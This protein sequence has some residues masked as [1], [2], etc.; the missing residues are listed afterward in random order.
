VRPSTPRNQGH[1][2][3]PVYAFM[4]QSTIP[5]GRLL[6][7]D[8]AAA[9]KSAGVLAVIT[10]FKRAKSSRRP[11]P[12]HPRGGISPCCRRRTSFIH[13]QPIALV[14]ARFHGRSHASGKS[15]TKFTIRKFPQCS[16]FPC[17]PRRSPAPLNLPV[18]EPATQTRGDVWLAAMAKGTVMVDHTY[19]TPY[20]H[21]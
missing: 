1:P 10:P 4:V 5:S 9:V 17:S 15:V 8:Q 2:L 3:N 12:N 19:T 21:Q 6:S 18:R 20:Q 14:V 11:A 13:G 16:I 7:I